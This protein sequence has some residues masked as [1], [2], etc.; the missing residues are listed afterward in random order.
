MAAIVATI[1]EP[2]IETPLKDCSESIWVGD[3]L[4]RLIRLV[5]LEYHDQRGS[6]TQS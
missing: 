3:Y 4:F 6:Q 1:L 5:I 2:Y